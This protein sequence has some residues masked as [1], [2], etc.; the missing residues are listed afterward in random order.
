MSVHRRRRTLKTAALAFIFCALALGSASADEIVLPAG[1]LERGR[2]A[3]VVYRLDPPVTGKA[4]LSIAWTDRDGRV[5]DR[6]TLPVTLDGSSDIGFSLDLARAVVMGNRL[7]ARLSLEAGASDRRE[8]EADAS[9]IVSPPDD[10]WSDYQIVMWQKRSPRQ[11][12]ALKSLGVGAAVAFRPPADRPALG[13]VVEPFL[14]A[15]LRWYVENIA[16]DF[17]SSYHRWTPGRPVDWR[18]IETK[19]LYRK[20]PR[21]VAPFIR[22]P[23][24]SDPVWLK[25]IHDRLFDTVRVFAPYRPLYYSLADE[26]GIAQTSSFWDF[27]LSE[28]SLKGMRD[29]LQTQYGTLAA[30]NRQWGTDFAAWDRVVPMTTRE[31]V[32]RTGDNFSAWADFKTWMDV[33]F[34]RALRAGTDAVHAADPKARAALEGGQI[35]GWGGYDYARLA[36]AVDIMELYDYGQNVDIVRSL[37]P[38]MIMLSTSGQSGPREAHRVWRALLRGNRGLILWD[39]KDEF[40]HQDGTLGPRGRDAAA[41]FNRIRDGLGALLINSE[42]HTDPI[43]M[44]YSPASFRTQWILDARPKGQAWS[45]RNTDSEYEDD[46]I[47]VPTRR[48]TSAIEHVGLQHRFV[49]SE[50]IEHGE[51]QRRGDRVL[52][53]PHAIA[54]SASEAEQIRRFVAQGGVVIADGE[55]GTFDRHSRRLDKPRLSDVFRD[56]PAGTM[57][58]F[59]YGKG[60]AIYLGS[61]GLNDRELADECARILADAGVR[62]EFPLTAAD[63]NPARDVET[64]VFRN[65]GATV[66]ALLR[67]PA[68]SG[69]S[70]TVVLTLPKSADVYD[71]LAKKSL[72][73]RDRLAVALGPVEPVILAV[74]DTAIPTPAISAPTRLRLGETATIRFRRIGVG[75]ELH[76]LHVEVADPTGA[77]VRHYSGNAF[78]A[79][80]TASWKLPLAVNDAAGTWRVRVT[81]VL[82]GRVDTSSIEIATP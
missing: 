28:H 82:T 65:G 38:R 9:F 3:D 25:R 37:N 1:I 42:R 4:V 80:E 70:E 21:S 23:S 39:A 61:G 43:A 62:P 47:R 17:Y 51:L 19:A 73:R 56:A 33:A 55:P 31:A 26:P 11:Y 2:S 29:W 76:V 66:I 36:T 10:P 18:F 79:G 74:G 67:N 30:L 58:T 27:D 15:G 71:L 32:T 63:G 5:V 6:R 64:Y 60:R 8:R 20:N 49:S 59:L 22:E 68:S 53:L 46:A 57:Q 77:T 52:I 16:T 69:D 34:A 35:P 75:G 12:A 81:D 44:L 14:D 78:L 24:L 40:V 54:L 45:E 41:Y 7:H 48:I 13:P 72:G 50:Q